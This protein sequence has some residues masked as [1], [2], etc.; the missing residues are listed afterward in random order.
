MQEGLGGIRDV[1]IDGSQPLLL[2]KFQRLDKQFRDAIAT[3][4]L[5]AA[6]PRFVVEASG[7]VLIAFLALFLAQGVGG[8]AGMLPAL[9][10]LALG[11]QRLNLTV[12]RFRCFFVI[13]IEPF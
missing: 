13:G 11:A 1:L 8:L 12:G 10:T 4:Y 6:A 9:G 5:I 3:N 7:L 2:S